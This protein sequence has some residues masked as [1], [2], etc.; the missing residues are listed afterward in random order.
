MLLVFDLT[1]ILLTSRENAPTGYEEY[2][3]DTPLTP[4][5]HREELELYDV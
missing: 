4:D 5:E 3:V 1:R 2:F